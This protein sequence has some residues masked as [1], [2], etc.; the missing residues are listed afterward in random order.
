MIGRKD[1][2]TPEKANLKYYYKIKADKGKNNAENN[3]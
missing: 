3:V 1:A 2:R